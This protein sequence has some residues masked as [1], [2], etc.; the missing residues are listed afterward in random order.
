[1]EFA[2]GVSAW[3]AGN[4]HI[5]GVEGIGDGSAVHRLGEVVRPTAGTGDDQSGGVDALVDADLGLGRLLPD[6]VA[7]EVVELAD[8]DLRREELAHLE[9]VCLHLVARWAEAGVTLVA[10]LHGAAVAVLDGLAVGCTLLDKGSFRVPP[11]G[12]VAAE[13]DDPGFV[14]SAGVG[15]VEERHELDDDGRRTVVAVN[16]RVVFARRPRGAIRAVVDV[17]GVAG[18]VVDE[19]ANGLVAE[20]DDDA[21]GYAEDA[22]LGGVLREQHLARRV[23]DLKDVVSVG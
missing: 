4:V 14:D 21:V 6:A 9:I 7:V 16:V 18:R 2:G 11:V 23:G 10:D 20:G 5:G 17:T 22:A 3:Y 8:F 19:A 15:R 12:H 13:G 1:M